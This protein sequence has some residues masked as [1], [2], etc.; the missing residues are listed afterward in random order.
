MTLLIKGQLSGLKARK[1]QSAEQSI[2]M[3]ESLVAESAVDPMDSNNANLNVNVKKKAV[4]I[5]GWAA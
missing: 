4:N 2:Q 3:V 1:P 5:V